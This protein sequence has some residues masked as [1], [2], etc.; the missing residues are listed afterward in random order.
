VTEVELSISWHPENAAPGEKEK[1]QRISFENLPLH[2]PTMTYNNQTWAWNDFYQHVRRDVIKSILVQFPGLV[3]KVMRGENV[4]ELER[5]Q[6][7]SFVSTNSSDQPQKKKKGII[8]SIASRFKSKE[9][10]ELDSTQI[11]DENSEMEKARLLFGKTLDKLKP[12]KQEPTK[13]II[14]QPFQ[15]YHTLYGEEIT[16]VKLEHDPLSPN[17]TTIP[18]ANLPN[19]S[20]DDIQKKK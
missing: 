13:D 12:K 15:Q 19:I 8:S 16:K 5:E 14:V 2:L 7:T 4:K 18:E 10:P 9:E 6:S 3:K 17:Q 11:G 20:T 1:K